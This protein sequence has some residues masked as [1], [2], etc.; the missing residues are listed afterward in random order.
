MVK[1][2]C[3]AYGEYGC[4][5]LEIQDCE[6]CKFYKTFKQEEQDNIKTIKRLKAKGSTEQYLRQ[7]KGY[8]AYRRSLSE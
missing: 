5:A 2:D 7:I 6:N 8:E 1:D 3:F 4:I